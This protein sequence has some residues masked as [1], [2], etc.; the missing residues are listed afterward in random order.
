[1]A[2]SMRRSRPSASSLRK[3]SC[4]SSGGP[5]AFTAVSAARLSSIDG[6]FGFLVLGDDRP[7]HPEAVDAD[8]RAAIDQDLR[9]RGADLVRCQPVVER[10]ADMGG[11][12]FHL[13]E[14]RDHAEIEYRTFA[15][16]Q[17]FVAPG[18]APAIFGQYPLKVAIEIVDVLQRTID[19]SV[20][21]HL[22]AFGKADLIT[23]LV[24]GV[25]SLL[26]SPPTDS[27]GGSKVIP[28]SRRPS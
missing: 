2:R 5:L 21:Q 10:A 13:A 25:S 7:R 22:S 1:M 9:Q 28:P 27:A 8:R 16:R 18:L 17:G 26:V 24:H 12:F 19:I 15:R 20:A 11:E 14:R 6:L 3:C 23:F 4:R